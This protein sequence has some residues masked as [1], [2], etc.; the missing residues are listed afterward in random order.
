MHAMLTFAKSGA[1][2][3]KGLG[4]DIGGG[5]QGPG[6]A[7]NDLQLG[8]DRSWGWSSGSVAVCASIMPKMRTDT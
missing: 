7:R 8:G 3:E 1:D 2:K 6:L 5:L 4:C